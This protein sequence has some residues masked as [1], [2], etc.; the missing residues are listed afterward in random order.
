MIV[1]PDA[2]LELAVDGALFSGFATAGQR[3]T[4]LG[5]LIIHSQIH[6]AFVEKL[7]H[8]AKNM[9]IGDPFNSD[10]T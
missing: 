9:R 6:D 1:C 4:S 7:V 2:D 5:N 3:C 8:K 10:V